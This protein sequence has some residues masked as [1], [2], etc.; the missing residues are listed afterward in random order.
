[1]KNRKITKEQYQKLFC[2]EKRIRERK[3]VYVSGG[4]QDILL[5]IVKM[6]PENHTTLSSLVEAIVLEHLKEH[7]DLLNELYTREKEDLV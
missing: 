6:F 1:M 5:K 7:K 2:Q 4:T 3:A